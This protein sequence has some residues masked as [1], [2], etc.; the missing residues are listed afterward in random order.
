MYIEVIQGPSP[1]ARVICQAM[2]AGIKLCGDSTHFIAEEFY[3][4]P[5]KDAAVFYGLHGR[6]RQAFIEYR[7]DRKAVYIDLGYWNRTEG[8]KLY[9]YHKISVNGRH[10]TAYFQHRAYP[11]DRI[12]H[13][14]VHIK[15][16]QPGGRHILV[17]GMGAKAA[18]VE[19]FKP[20]E[21]E[22]AAVREL[23]RHTDRPLI[24]R[25]KPSWNSEE[26]ISGTIFSGKEQR[27]EEVLKDCH[28]VV[29]HHSNVCVD[30]LVE[31][32]PVF[33]FHGVASVMGLK[34]LSMIENPIYPDGREQWAANIAYTQWRPDEMKTG[35]AW[36]YLK[37]EG[38]V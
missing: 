35:A 21:W 12:R 6:L 8:G 1:R 31:G 7:R 9:G 23:S 36:R 33:C 13:L 30:A 2:D 25:P 4:G 11:D 27:L 20:L 17:A 34:E 32:I 18:L 24:Y 22:M 38:I 16:W 26:R 5:T 3:N 15:P 37:D 19:G 28:A 29:S 10:P 14:G